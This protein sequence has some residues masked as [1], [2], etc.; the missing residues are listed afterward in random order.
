MTAIAFLFLSASCATSAVPAT[1]ET[2]EVDVKIAQ[3]PDDGFAVQD[4]GAVSVAFQMTVRNGSADAITLRNVVMKTTGRSPYSLREDPAALSERIEAGQE[5]TL[6]FTMWS[7][8]RTQPATAHSVVY[9]SGTLHYD[10]ARGT[11]Q[12]EFTQFFREP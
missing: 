4:R 5:A 1:G 3:L 8:T 12:K 6:T 10:S 11:F 2:G 9:V 7:H